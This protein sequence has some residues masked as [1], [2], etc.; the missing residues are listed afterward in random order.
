MQCNAGP[1]YLQV[2]SKIISVRL[3]IQYIVGTQ[4]HLMLLSKWIY[5]L[6]FPVCTVL[7]NLHSAL[8]C[9]AQW[10][11]CTALHNIH[12]AL[13]YTASYTVLYNVYVALHCTI[14]TVRC[15]ALHNMHSAL[16]C[17]TSYKEW[18]N[19]KRFRRIMLGITVVTVVRKKTFFT[20]KLFFHHKNFTGKNFNLQKE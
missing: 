2:I 4:I 1:A 17:S 11:N 10:K 6:C 8:P 20:K 14:Y 13:H 3:F 7:Y 19:I 18:T 16:H 12:N 15:T 9:T 5:R